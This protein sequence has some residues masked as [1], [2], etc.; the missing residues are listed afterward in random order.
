MLPVSLD[1]ALQPLPAAPLAA[2]LSTVAETRLPSLAGITRP[3]L[4]KAL[5][6]IG[7]PEREVRMRAGQLWH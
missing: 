3:E 6:D 1:T 2:D 7:V 5:A 4:A